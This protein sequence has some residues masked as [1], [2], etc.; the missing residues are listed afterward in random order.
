MSEKETVMTISELLNTEY[1]PRSWG[2]YY[3]KQLRFVQEAYSMM[4]LGQTP[5]EILEFMMSEK[6]S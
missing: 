2:M 5:L 4:K 6:K 3:K 1:P